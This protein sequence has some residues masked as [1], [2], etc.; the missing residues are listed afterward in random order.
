VLLFAAGAARAD[1]PKILVLPVTGKAADPGFRQRVTQSLSEGLIASGGE[2]VAP[3]ASV[4][5]EGCATPA[6]LAGAARATGAAYLLRATVDEAGRSYLFKLEML[7]GQSGAVLAQRENRCEIC[8]DAEALE[9]A[10]AAASALKAQAFKKPGTP[11]TGAAAAATPG[12]TTAAPGVTAAPEKPAGPRARV[13]VV[14]KLEL[15]ASLAEFHGKLRTALEALVREQG[16][17]VVTAPAA[18]TPACTGPDCQKDQLRD[19]G[20]SH[21]LYVEGSRNDYG[22]SLDITL[23]GVSGDDSEKAQGWCNFCTGPQMVTAAENVARPLVVHL[24][25]RPERAPGIATGTKGTDLTAKTGEGKGGSSTARLLVGIGLAAAGAA[26]AVAG[27]ITWSRAGDD[28]DCAAPMSNPAGT[29]ICRSTY[30]GKPLGIAMT[31]GGGVLVG[32]GAWMILF[33]GSGD[34]RVGVGPNS[35]AFTGRF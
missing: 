4:P 21:V 26:T 33:R 2:V 5:A 32:V 31:V 11:A 1:R 27:G 18:P 14:D 28:T 34:T 22:F 25:A 6:C 29:P 16:L 20:A 7:D 8:T 17:E 9:I 24:A 15:P 19:A 3:G 30:G 35:V 23:R 12:A 10:N 13:G